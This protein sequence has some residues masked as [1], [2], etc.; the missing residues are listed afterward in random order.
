MVNLG[1]IICSSIYAQDRMNLFRL[2]TID[3]AVTG[4]RKQVAISFELP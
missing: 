3:L 4:A 1:G 2:I